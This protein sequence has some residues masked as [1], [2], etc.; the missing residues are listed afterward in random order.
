MKTTGELG[1]LVKHGTRE[2]LAGPDF[3]SMPAHEYL[4]KLLDDRKLKTTDLISRCNLDRSYAYQLVNG[5]RVPSRDLILSIGLELRFTE[6]EM[7][8]MLKLAERPVLYVRNRRD[9]AILYALGNNLGRDG[10]ADL[11][12]ELGEEGLV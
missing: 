3:D 11:L 7:Q 2:E 12:R 10:A 5:T 8:R 4:R 1:K 9:A 6:R